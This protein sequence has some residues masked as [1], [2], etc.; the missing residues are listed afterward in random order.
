MPQRP[1]L[2]RVVVLSAIAFAVLA[3]Y[4]VARPATK[5]LFVSAHGASAEPGAWVLVAA[6]SLA[7]VA[8]YGRFAARMT[9][10][11]LLGACVVTSAAI[12]A[13]LQLALAA[14]LPGV[15]YALYVW[16]DVYVV[17]LIEAFWMFANSVHPLKTARW[18]YGL[19]L[20]AGSAGSFAGAHLV[21]RL[22][23][24]HGTA[25]SLWAVVPLLGVAWLGVV[26]LGRVVESARPPP[27][28]SAPTMR[29]SLRLLRES[30]YLLHLLLLI[31]VIQFVMTL[32]DFRLSAAVE[33]EIADPDA[34]TAAIAEVFRA[35]ALGALTLQLLAGP[36]L[37]L[38]GV[39]GSL[40]AVPAINAVVLTLAA[41]EPRFVLVAAGLAV[42]KILDYSVFRAAKEMLYI[43]MTY[44]E[45]TRGKAVV[46]ML[47]Y[48]VAK[49]L[50]ALL[51]QGLVVL[52]AAAASG[53]IAVAALAVWL[54]LTLAI[55]R[56]WRERESTGSA[57]RP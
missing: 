23:P 15:Y 32:A 54:G 30:P 9:L 53:F 43:P 17:V 28:R 40:V 31:L 50:T 38:A 12:L 35:I 16:R 37:R 33:A 5:S 52:G 21:G 1:S 39:A 44:E 46:D 48:R 36:I 47:T 18:V 7:V 2:A 13:A 24:V 22:A 3:S 41:V 34:R 56:R 14:R 45:Q 20:A 8:L 42:A 25:T 4:E 6:A 49:G 51:L 10:V 19:F 11:R 26:V 55:A 57:E 29:E 27:T